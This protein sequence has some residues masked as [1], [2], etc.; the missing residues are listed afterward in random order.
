MAL[1]KIVFAPGINRDR[2]NYS[3]T[4]GWYSGDK[5]RFRQGYPEKIGGW[6]PINFD[7]FI[8]E[9]SSL[10]SY[11]TTDNQS[12][13]GIGT[14]QKMYVLVSTTLYDTTPIRA[15]F[16]SPATDDCFGT[17]DTSTTLLVTIVDHGANDGD[18]VTFSGAVDVGGI[19]A[20]ELNIEHVISNV[21]VD[22][23]EITVTT[24]ATSTVAAGGGTAITAAFQIS[25][26]FAFTV[27]G[28][29]WGAG[30]WGRGT[31]GSASTEPAASLARIIYQ[32][33]FNNSII[34]NLQGGD[35]YYWEYNSA[36][37]NRGV[38]LNTLLN[39]RAVPQQV[40][41]TIFTPSGH[42]LALAC[43]EYSETYTAGQT[44]STITR[45][46]TTATVTTATAHGLE[47]YDWV[48]F[49]GQA[50]QVYQGEYQVVTVPTTSTFT[51]A[52]PYDPGANAT[53][54]GTYQK[55]N[56]D[57]GA[58][59]P[60]LIRWSNVDPNFGPQPEEW[61]PEITNNA[62]FLRVKQGSAIISAIRTR[63][64][65]LI[66]TDIALTT[67]QFLGTDEVFGSQEISS[68]INLMGPNVV[69]E[70]NNVVYW[71]GNDKFFMYDGRVNTLPCTLKQ[72]VFEDINRAQGYV[73][74]AGVNSEF[75]E[76]I[77]FYASAN[78]NIINRYVIYNFMENIW[79]YG[80]LSRTTWVDSGAVK[81]PLSTNNGYVY[82]HE[83]GKD[84]GQPA[85]EDPLPI[86][87]FIQSAD[88]TIEDGDNFILT[89]RVIPDVNFIN[90]ETSNP[91]TGATLVPEVQ[92][93]VGVRN[94]PGA[95]NNQT[96][97]EGLT[98]TRDVITT[99]TINTYTNQ[100]FVRARG[101]QMN[102]KIASNTLGV[103]W[104]LGS[105]RIDFKPDGRRGG[106]F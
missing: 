99:A 24:P 17:T 11:G 18:Y 62:G 75:N 53:T 78:S 27:Y 31:W 14:N 48:L 9:A 21:T 47:P 74:C 77:W 28:Y 15:T 57:G 70:V 22:T 51:I 94:F 58:Y 54:L 2:T 60:L 16:T 33:Q 67:L 96:D 90:S 97:V 5:I 40:N 79:Y 65:V 12:I 56:Y 39:S 69:A 98:L 1:K 25:V 52:L 43:T 66:F 103:Q 34:Y 7:P 63:Q 8:G 30:I 3:S 86:E 20:G 50:P 41:R 93:T 19:P 73:F 44:I 49:S 13:V 35:I 71:M 23:F 32:N 89:K 85:G 88:M 91:V 105:T 26:G 64:E 92:M 10:I 42:L 84:D 61:K 59:D 29:G 6:N 37:S 76:V 46:G 95:T 102:F 100:V 80:S 38:A 83:D 55:V 106:V 82:Q 81:F 45:T 101:R 68:A 72:Y 87:S 104:E 36:I 4:G